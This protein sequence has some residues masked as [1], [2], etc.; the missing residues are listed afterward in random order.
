MFSLPIHICVYS[1]IKPYTY[2][3]ILFYEYLVQIIYMKMQMYIEPM[4]HIPNKELLEFMRKTKE[5]HKQ[6]K[7]IT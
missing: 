3:P 1:Y 5:K 4:T 7:K 2:L 6:S